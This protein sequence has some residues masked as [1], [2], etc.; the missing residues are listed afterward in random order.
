MESNSETNIYYYLLEAMMD[1]NDW[2]FYDE[3]KSCSKQNILYHVYLKCISSNRKMLIST[4][5]NLNGTTSTKKND[6]QKKNDKAIDRQVKWDEQ[7]E[8]DC[9][10]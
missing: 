5:Q 2:K 10:K 6:E 3:I 9:C 7:Y 8:T 4:S 1:F